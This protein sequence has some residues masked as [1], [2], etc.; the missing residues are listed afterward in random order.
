MPKRKEQELDEIVKRKITSKDE[1]ITTN[2]VISGT[3]GDEMKGYDKWFD[4]LK[5]SLNFPIDATIDL[6]NYS[7]VFRDGDQVKITKLL[8][9]ADMYGILAEVKFEGR[10]YVTALCELE[11][12]KQKSNNYYLILFYNIWFSNR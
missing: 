12:V 5:S 10:K 1:E 4:F 7:S 3:K 2:K 11:V 6:Y 9:Y 8:S